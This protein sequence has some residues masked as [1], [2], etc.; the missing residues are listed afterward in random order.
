MDNRQKM[1]IAA[2]MAAG[3]A[4][5]PIAVSASKTFER[6]TLM[7]SLMDRP[8]NGAIMHDHTIR[9][10]DFSLWVSSNKKLVLNNVRRLPRDAAKEIKEYTHSKSRNDNDRVIVVANFYDLDGDLV[11]ELSSLLGNNA[12][13]NVRYFAVTPL[14]PLMKYIILRNVRESYEEFAQSDQGRKLAEI[15]KAVADKEFD[16]SKCIVAINCDPEFFWKMYMGENGQ[17]HDDMGIGI[18]MK[19]IGFNAKI[20]DPSTFEFELEMTISNKHEIARKV[21]E[22]KKSKKS[23]TDRANSSSK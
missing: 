13:M 8:K 5:S 10:A 1:T 16:I 2:I 12:I 19:I 4:A 3:I 17:K 6:K 11:D 20:D 21:S 18:G 9:N 7:E 23:K 15:V 22:Y 14:G